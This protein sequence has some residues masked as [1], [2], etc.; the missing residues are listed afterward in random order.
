MSRKHSPAAR[1]KQS[2]KITAMHAALCKCDHQRRRHRNWT[3]EC[4]ECP[5]QAFKPIGARP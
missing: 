3:W 2:E 4:R 1:R 5:C